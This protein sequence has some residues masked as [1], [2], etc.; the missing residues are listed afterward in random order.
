MVDFLKTFSTV[1]YTNITLSHTSVASVD[2]KTEGEREREADREKG[3]K[4]TNQQ[5]DR[6]NNIWERI[7]LTDSLSVFMYVRFSLMDPSGP[8]REAPGFN[9]EPQDM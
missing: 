7:R 3:G 9:D 8:Q 2:N 5:H 4:Q 1:G 6:M